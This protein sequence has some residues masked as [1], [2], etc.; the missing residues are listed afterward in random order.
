MSKL[1]LSFCVIKEK[2][3]HYKQFLF[4]PSAAFC[5]FPHTTL[6][7]ASEA[8]ESFESIV[9]NEEIAKISN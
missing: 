5:P 7:N 6:S 9:A 1:P 3:D 4:L 2:I 8:D